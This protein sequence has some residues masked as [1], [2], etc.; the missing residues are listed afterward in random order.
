MEGET[1]GVEAWG[2]YRMMDGWFVSAGLNLMHQD[3]G[4]EPESFQL[5]G[6]ETAGNDPDEQFFLRSAWTIS[7][8]FDLDVD[9]RY[10][11][12]LPNPK[13]P[14]YFGLNA[15]LAWHATDRIDLVLSGANLAGS[16]RE[17]GPAGSIEFSPSVLLTLQW[18]G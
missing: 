3:L 10:V 12:E 16:H 1:Y 9:A 4:F 11:G 15:R 8:D 14:G 2:T 17:F 18:R 7:P 5:Q 6:I 13:V